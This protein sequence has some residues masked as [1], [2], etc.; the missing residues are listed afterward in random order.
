MLFVSLCYSLTSRSLLILSFLLLLLSRFLSFLSSSVST[1]LEESEDG[2]GGWEA[3][4]QEPLGEGSILWGSVLATVLLQGQRTQTMWSTTSVVW[5]HA[6]PGVRSKNS[7]PPFPSVIM[8]DD[9]VRWTLNLNHHP[10]FNCCEL[11]VRTSLLFASILASVAIET[12]GTE[13]CRA[14]C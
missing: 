1:F 2:G 7:N 6:V 4:R 8:H 13:T 10:R 11:L 5:R 14:I 9:N 12:F 3:L